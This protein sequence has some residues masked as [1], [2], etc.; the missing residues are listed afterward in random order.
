MSQEQKEALDAMLREAPLDLGGELEEQRA[1]FEEMMS[2]IP[3]SDAVQASP[4]TVG[5]VEGVGVT[6]PGAGSDAIILYLHGGAYAIGSATSAVPLAADLAQR[7]HINLVAIDYRLAPEHPYPAA[8]DDA[9]AAYEGLLG[10]GFA[11]DKIAIAGESAGAGLVVATLLSLR[12]ADRPMPA[13]AYLMSPWVDLTL[14]GDSIVEKAAVDPSLN[15]AG[16]R[17]R[18]AD[19]LAAANA[20]DPRVSPVGA[21]LTRLPPLLIQVGTHEI[22]LSDAL[23]LAARAG[24]GEVD[25]TLEITAGVPHIFQAFAA[26]LDEG[27][28]ALDRGAHFLNNHLVVVAS[29]AADAEREPVAS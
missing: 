27:S 5:G 8:I 17:R 23:R 20:G 26:M 4:R 16:L 28:Q 7:A 6:V 11:P 10:E 3:V 9:V 14:S 1:I 15:A 21:D 2:H 18:A 22:L 29:A 12:D 19:Y 25:A 24:A 13:C